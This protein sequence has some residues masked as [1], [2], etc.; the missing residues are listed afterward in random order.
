[1]RQTDNSRKYNQLRAAFPRFVYETARAEKT[2][3]GISLQFVFSQND[4]LVFKPSMFF[5][6]KGRFLNLPDELL[7]TFAFHVGMV[8]MISYWK[9]FCSP[10]ILVMPFRLNTGQEQWWKKL[11][12]FGLGEFFYTN[13]I[14]VP[15]EEMLSFEYPAEAAYFK[16]F[17]LE[18][19]TESIIIP[20]GGG[21]DS[22]VTLELLK[23]SGADILPLVM[24]QRGATRQV[25]EAAGFGPEDTLEIHRTLDPLLLKLNEQ[26]FLNGHTPFSALLAFMTTFAATL[27]GK[28]HI[29]LSNESSANEASIPGTKINHQY[30]KS[31]EFEQ[32]FRNYLSDYLLGEVN[33]FSF[34][35]PLNELQIGALFSGFQQYHGVFKSCNAGSKTDSWCCNCSKCLFTYT[36]LAPFIKEE[37][38][39]AI[40]GENLFEKVSLAPILDQLTGV[41]E[42]KPFE[43]VGTLDEVNAALQEAIRQKKERKLPPL[44]QH[45]KNQQSAIPGQNNFDEFLNDFHEPHALQPRFKT[46]LQE[47]IKSLLPIDNKF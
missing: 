43:C 22:V 13:G 39:A 6:D 21:K 42:I 25:L 40:F 17:E 15:G 8:E 28:R 47:S 7:Q 30:S 9:A 10:R 46:L 27:T 12:R 23:N 3:E 32:D 16:K 38:M 5:P 45:Y 37:K 18:N 34:L 31:F 20:V 41:A 36:I 35:R 2:A 19:F 29:A 14:E 11:F 24:N 4:E 26:G 33:Y 1:M 44:L